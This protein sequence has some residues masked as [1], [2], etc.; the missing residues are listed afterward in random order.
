MCSISG[1][2]RN[3]SPSIVIVTWFGAWLSFRCSFRLFAFKFS[4][5]NSL[6]RTLS[7]RLFA[8][9]SLSLS[10][11]L[12]QTL[13]LQTHWLLVLALFL[14]DMVSSV[15]N[16]NPVVFH[17]LCSLVLLK[18]VAVVLRRTS[19]TSRTRPDKVDNVDNIHSGYVHCR[20]ATIIPRSTIQF[21]QFYQFN[22]NLLSIRDLSLN[23]PSTRRN[24]IAATPVCLCWSPI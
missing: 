18:L 24:P 16:G 2:L 17:L 10:F 9:N 21:L 23:I 12:F 5:S 6:L 20:S 8:S 15:A 11:S 1:Y 13:W 22:Q 14:F 4:R 7:F 19:R 3:W